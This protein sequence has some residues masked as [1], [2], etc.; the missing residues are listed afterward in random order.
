MY[1]FRYK[2]YNKIKR[3][4]SR[5]CSHNIGGDESG[6][7]ASGRQLPQR[8]QSGDE[9]AEG[10]RQAPLRLDRPQ[11]A[12]EGGQLQVRFLLVGRQADE[13]HFRRRVTSKRPGVL[14]H[15]AGNSHLH[16]GVRGS[17]AET[18]R[19]GVGQRKAEESE[20][21]A[22]FSAELVAVVQQR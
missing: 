21:K 6:R 15:L 11:P 10:H 7:Q 2:T 13:G 16:L 17:D 3:M 8:V 18:N 14:E 22:F 12:D 5:R 20:Q 9:Q 19:D 1:F 4:L